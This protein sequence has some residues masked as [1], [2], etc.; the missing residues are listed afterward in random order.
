MEALQQDLTRVT[1]NQVV[2]INYQVKN[3]GGE[4][5]DTNVGLEPVSYLHG[6]GNIIPGLERALS[7]LV[8]GE[9]VTFNIS[10]E[11]GYGHRDEG[12]VTLIA[13]ADLPADMIFEPGMV[14]ES[15]MPDGGHEQL[16]VVEVN[17]N[18]ITFDANHPLAGQ[19]LFYE[20]D[21]VAVRNATA[22]EI[23]AGAPL[24]LTDCGPGCRC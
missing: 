7:R 19:H 21:V 13:R 8:A 2:T 20:V 9:H 17:E 24:P 6:A 4:L 5:L 18:F 15:V 3:A 10:P 22:A 23:K 16:V 14:C 1:N 12:L 11:D